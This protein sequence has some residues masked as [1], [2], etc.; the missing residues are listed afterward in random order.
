MGLDAV[1]IFGASKSYGWGHGDLG[2]GGRHG[3]GRRMDEGAGHRAHRP[4]SRRYR[5]VTTLCG[6]AKEISNEK[7][8]MVKKLLSTV[9]DIIMV[10]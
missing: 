3:L 7:S 9:R 5:W 1:A 2:P 10:R 6:L 8:A 4:S